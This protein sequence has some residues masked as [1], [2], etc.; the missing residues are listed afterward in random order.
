[1]IYPV[2]II[3]AVDSNNGI[4]KD[5]SIPWRIKKDMKYFKDKTT[6]TTDENLKNVVIMGRKTWDSFPVKFK[7]LPGRINIIISKTLS[8]I[9]GVFICD[10]Y[11]SA[12]QKAQSLQDIETIWI[13]G[14]SQIYSEAWAGDWNETYIT[15]INKNYD[16]DTFDNF[17]NGKKISSLADTEGEI[18]FTFEI[19]TP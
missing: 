19:Y 4:G 2:K 10:S 13:C 14:G 18:G 16:C 15:R 6:N 3:V 7:P 8:D 9:E 11:V 1:M 5:N 12:V 17:T